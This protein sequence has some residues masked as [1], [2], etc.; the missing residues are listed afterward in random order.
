MNVFSKTKQQI[1]IALCDSIDTPT[2]MKHIRELISTTNTY[3]NT[4]NAIINR[5]LLR[6]I[7]VYI[8]RL[9][10]IFGLNSSSL[11]VD[12]DIN[13][14]RLNEQQTGTVNIEVIAMPYMEAF[15]SFRDDVRKQ[16]IAIRNK[17]ILTLCDR[18]RNETFPK[19][20]FR[21]EDQAGTNKAMIKYCGVEVLKQEREQAS[22]VK[23][24][25]Q[26]EEQQSAKETKAPKK[27]ASKE[28]K[29]PDTKDSSQVTTIQQLS[30]LTLSP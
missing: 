5:L 16:A 6:N 28:K 4:K 30:M 19:L 13:F 1:H 12:N 3:M 21:L 24:G 10:D 20:G 18:E 2:V 25:H 29:D 26:E 11:A 15:A 8:T 17:E 23:N 27:K 14:N 22:A 7:A 9:L